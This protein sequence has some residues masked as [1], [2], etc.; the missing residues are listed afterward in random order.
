MRTEKNIH[1]GIISWSN[2]KFSELT[3]IMRIVWLTI[4]RIT[5]FI[6]EL[7][8]LNDLLEDRGIK[9]VT[10]NIFATLSYNTNKFHVTGLFCNRLQK[11][12]KCGGNISDTLTM[13]SVPL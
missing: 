6:W 4:W 11:M 5:I 3:L 8:G 1:L 12:S 9:D 2:P 13:P 10:I 7:K